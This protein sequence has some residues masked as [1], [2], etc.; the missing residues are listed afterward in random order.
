MAARMARSSA[1][2]KFHAPAAKV[3][4][5][6]HLLKVD[7]Q[8]ELNAPWEVGLVAYD[9]ETRRVID[10]RVGVPELRSIEDIEKLGFEFHVEHFT[11]FRHVRAFN[12]GKV[13]VQG[14]KRAQTRLHAA[15]VPDGER[16]RLRESIDVQVQIRCRIERS[17][18]TRPLR[19][20]WHAV[21]P[22]AAVE[23]QQVRAAANSNRSS[24]SIARDPSDNPALGKL[25]YGS[26]RILPERHLVDPAHD[27]IVG[28]VIS[29]Q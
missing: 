14:R 2:W 25:C 6:T 16:R 10:V 4:R 27:N 22:V 12:R 18:E 28:L 8:A 17:L 29:S 1:R 23:D 9:A 26:S 3:A 11:D 13:F 19:D 24:A 15:H 5:V 21:G 7:P 20:S